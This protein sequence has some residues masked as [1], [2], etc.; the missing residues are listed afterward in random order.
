[1]EI[2]GFEKALCKEIVFSAYIKNF[3]L[4][5]FGNL[6]EFERGE[7]WALP[8]WQPKA[9]SQS[10]EITVKKEGALGAPFVEKKGLLFEKAFF[11]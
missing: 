5:F 11:S 9:L 10:G 7:G 2:W 4:F 6:G 8:D 1:M 3:F